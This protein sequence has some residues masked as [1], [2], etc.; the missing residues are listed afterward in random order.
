MERVYANNIAYDFETL[1][2]GWIAIYEVNTETG[3]RIPYIQ[4]KDRPHAMTSVN[5]RERIRVPFG[6]LCANNDD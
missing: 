5:L 1:D 6:I 2:D 4:A 3:E